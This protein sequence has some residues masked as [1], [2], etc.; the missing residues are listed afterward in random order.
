MKIAILILLTGLCNGLFLAFGFT[1]ACAIIL[2]NQVEGK[3][4]TQ[5]PLKL[6][7]KQAK[8]Q[9]E[10][11]KRRQELA[12]TMLHNIDVYDGTDKDQRNVTS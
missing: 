7:R 4:W 12:E 1:A 3:H 5:K 11:E 8:E 2:A 10:E 6:S 9:R